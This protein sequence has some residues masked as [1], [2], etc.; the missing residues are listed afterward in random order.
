MATIEEA[1]QY[2]QQVS[3]L[4]D[5]AIV[6]AYKLAEQKKTSKRLIASYELSFGGSKKKYDISDEIA[7]IEEK[8]QALQV[9]KEKWLSKRQE[10]ETFINTLAL[11]PKIKQVLSLKYICGD[12]WKEI[13]DKLCYSERQILRFH[14]I[15]LKKV[16]NILKDVS[17]CQ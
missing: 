1:K 2:L 13:A 11:K 3:E 8:E 5:E 6:L 9:A 14:L 4:R 7:K 16:A 17:K 10:I 15:G 12:R